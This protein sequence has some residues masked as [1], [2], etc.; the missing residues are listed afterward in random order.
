MKI[1]TKFKKD[2][3]K[4]VGVSQKKWMIGAILMCFSHEM[5]FSNNAKVIKL[6]VRGF[7]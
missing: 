7:F 5:N 1:K 2:E 4:C 6:N 3:N